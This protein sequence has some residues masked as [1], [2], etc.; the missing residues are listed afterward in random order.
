M[1]GGNDYDFL[2]DAYFI[3]SIKFVPLSSQ[4]WWNN[5]YIY[6]TPNRPNILQRSGNGELIVRLD[7]THK[8]SEKNYHSSN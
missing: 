2:E 7:I 1:T 8:F 3:W 4:L 5:I 6:L